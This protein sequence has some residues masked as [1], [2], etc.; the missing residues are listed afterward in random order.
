MS[1]NPARRWLRSVFRTASTVICMMLWLSGPL[2]A[3]EESDLEFDESAESA[4]DLATARETL[5]QTLPPGTSRDEEV[6][7]WL[8]RERA[9]FVAGAN[10]VRLESLR[11]LVELHKDTPQVYRYWGSLWRE[12]WRSG[13]QQKAFEI[14]EQIV[15]SNVPNLYLKTQYAAS[16][17]WD[18]SEIG[19]RSRAWSAIERAERY[20]KEYAQDPSNP[21]TDR[22]AATIRA[23]I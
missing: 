20:A 3:Q 23:T 4:P 13:N 2:C 18:Y 14:G 8:A 19:D 22:V 12:E 9:A 21:Y 17:A 16:L 7:Y 1:G 11:R 5:K 10:A 6:R 15:A